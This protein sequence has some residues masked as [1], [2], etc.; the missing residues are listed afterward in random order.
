MKKLLLLSCVALIAVSCEKDP[1]ADKMDAD[2]VVY[3]DYDDSADFGQRKTCLNG[4]VEE[5]ADNHAQIQFGSFEGIRNINVR[6]HRDAMRRRHRIR[7]DSSNDDID[8][9][10]PHH[11]D[12]ADCLR[13]LESFS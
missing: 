4:V 10:T 3:T 9:G 12:W 8:A 7:T 2:L 13:L 1:D 6:L 11:V 5:I